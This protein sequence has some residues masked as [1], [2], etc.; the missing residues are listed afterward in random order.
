MQTGETDKK[1]NY[2][3]GQT[4]QLSLTTSQCTGKIANMRIAYSIFQTFTIQ[5]ALLYLLSHKWGLD[6]FPILEGRRNTEFLSS[7][8]VCGGG[9]VG[10]QKRVYT[11]LGQ[12]RL[13]AFVVC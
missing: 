9:G 7:V 10:Y 6:P 13:S 8:C 1:L 12:L 4:E 11:E 5:I 2:V 3:H